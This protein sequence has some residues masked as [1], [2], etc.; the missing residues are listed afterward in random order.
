MDFQIINL[1]VGLLFLMIINIVLGSIASIFESKFDKNK[2]I[3]GMV[4]GG[5]VL[6]CFIGTFYV[7]ILNPDIIV[8]N[9]NGQDVDL[10]TGTHM[11]LLAGYVWYGKEV[12]TKLI[13]FIAGKLEINEKQNL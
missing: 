9:I 7:G 3:K 5:I 1:S 12:L 2:L 11:I 8:A 13:T 4:K 10:L 6:G